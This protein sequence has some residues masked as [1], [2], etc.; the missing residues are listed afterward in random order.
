MGVYLL[1]HSLAIY[2]GLIGGILF[3]KWNLFYY[4]IVRYP[5]KDIQNY[6]KE[7]FISNLSLLIMVIVGFTIWRILYARLKNVIRNTYILFRVIFF[8]V[9][10]IILLVLCHF[11]AHC[12][13]GRYQSF[14][15][16]MFMI[17]Y[18]D[19]FYVSDDGKLLLLDYNYAYALF[20]I[21]HSWILS[22]WLTSFIVS[23]RLKKK[24]KTLQ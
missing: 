21:I 2:I 22:L 17:T 10:C 5:T 24:L 4:I 1:V 16:W 6:Y 18:P 12:L 20:F 13:A 11:V 8:C 15:S 19:P 23:K 7:F 14:S 9:N 3:G